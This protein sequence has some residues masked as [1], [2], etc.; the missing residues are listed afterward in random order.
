MRR[1]PR[2]RRRNHL[3][4]LKNPFLLSYMRDALIFTEAKAFL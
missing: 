2:G 4:L 1:L 3:S